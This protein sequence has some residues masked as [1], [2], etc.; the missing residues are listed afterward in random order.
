MDVDTR[1]W[2][3]IETQNLLNMQAVCGYT[4]EKETAT[5]MQILFKK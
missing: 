5:Y 1:I 4:H 2:I 3:C